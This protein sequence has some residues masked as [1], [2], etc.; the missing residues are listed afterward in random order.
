MKKGYKGFTIEEVAQQAR[1][2]KPTIYRW[3]PDKSRL[4]AEL[5]DLESRDPVLVSDTLS[6]KERYRHLLH[7]LWTLWETTVCGEA[8][9]CFIA[10]S[11]L[12]IQNMAY[13]VDEFMV[14]RFELP[15]TLLEQGVEQGELKSDTDIDLLLDISFGF[16]WFHL[17]T[18]KL[19][20]RTRIDAF[21]EQLFG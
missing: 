7:E 20:D 18:N 13:M 17:L 19:T 9:R 11:Q 14:R 5:Y 1:V 10:E 6:L 2:S 4:V 15:R 16:C 8:L 3:W 12:N 21:I